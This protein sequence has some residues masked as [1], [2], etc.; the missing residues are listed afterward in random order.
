MMHQE[1]MHQTDKHRTNQEIP[2]RKT[3]DVIK[4]KQI[5]I[6]MFTCMMEESQLLPARK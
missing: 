3:I 6:K 1:T 4:E 2:V 5:A